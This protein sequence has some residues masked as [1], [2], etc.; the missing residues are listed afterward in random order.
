MK[1]N[2]AAKN[3]VK[4]D[5][6]GLKYG[7]ISVAI[8]IVF[9]AVV[10]LINVIVGILTDRYAFKFDM[11][12][13]QRFAIS[14]ETKDV[15]KDME[16]NITV[17]VFAT[18]DK[19]RSLYY[20]NEIVE[21]LYRYEAASDG[22]LTLQFV[23]PLRNPD[24]V[25]KY[26][27]EASNLSEYSIIVEDETGKFRTIPVEDVYYWYDA[28]RTSIVGLSLERRL[29][30]AIVWLESDEQPVAAVLTGNG[31]IA[32]GGIVSL[33]KDNNFKVINVNLLTEDI[34]EEVSLIVISSPEYD[35]TPEELT[36]LDK[37][38]ERYKWAIVALPANS[39]SLP[40]FEL[41][42]NEW[43]VSYGR[44]TVLDSQYKLT[45][46][47]SAVVSGPA[48]TDKLLTGV[49][50]VVTPVSRPISILWPSSDRFYGRM[51]TPL[52]ST[53]PTSYARPW[54]EDQTIET[55]ERQEGD[56]SG[57][58]YAAVLTTQTTIRDNVTLEGGV[59]FLSTPYLYDESLTSLNAYGNMTF[60][61][62][63]IGEFSPS[64]V[65]VNVKN[66]SFTSPELAV[67]G[68]KLTVV[69]VLLCLIPAAILITGGVVWFRRKNR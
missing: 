31:E 20:G 55:Y 8:S 42:L 3:A 34:P 60:M 12:S 10:I 54:G 37:Y 17:Y 53:F 28:S 41:F 65:R 64:G 45:A 47:Y 9:V 66:K 26:K 57:P 22:K 38:F 43:G 18:E 32:Y 6:R 36:K 39:P 67:I 19:Y 58:F 50:Y 25:N 16:H 11:T 63:V 24:F 7:S 2:T 51:T 61:S 15:L 52:L 49:G 21:I 30:A 13:D 48:S 14:R 46:D 4:K 59:L 1:K 68:N 40:E 69:L 35:Y 5:R 23:D 29:T 44:A 33:L 56:L 27:S 62:N